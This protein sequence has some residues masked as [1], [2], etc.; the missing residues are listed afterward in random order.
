MKRLSVVRS[1]SASA[2]ETPD[3]AGR[4]VV[5]VGLDWTRDKDPRVPLGQA[6]LAAS[7]KA[8][9]AEVHSMCYSINESGLD[10]EGAVADVLAAAWTGRGWADLGIGVYVWNDGAVRALCRRLRERGFIGRIVLGGPQITYHGPGVDQRY[11]DADALVRG[12]GEA[13]LPQI[14]ASRGPVPIPG[15]CWRGEADRCEQASAALE[16][17]PSPYLTGVLDPVAHRRFLRWETKRGCL[18]RC[19]FCQHRDPGARPVVSGFAEDR[20]K[21]EIALF[22][23]AGVEEIA[24]LDPIFN[25]P[26]SPYL[27][28]LDGFIAAEFRG[29]L[30]LQCRFELVDR[31]FLERVS[32]I[33]AQLEFGLQTIHP[34]EWKGIHRGNQMDKVESAIVELQRRGI[35]FEVSLIYGLPDQTLASFRATVQWC[36]ERGVPV[37]KAFPL[38]LLRGTE[39]EQKR[40]QW[41]LVESEDTIPMVI[42]SDSFTREEHHEMQTIS[43]ALIATEGRHPRSIDELVGRMVGPVHRARWTP[44]G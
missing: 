42:A 38:M 27:E 25:D 17:L 5:L 35:F 19:S 22:A 31:A 9:G 43:E 10:I 18:Y 32:Q 21:A 44:V 15:V 14:V 37:I 39:I 11:P 34:R 20:V 40:E 2:G 12:A 30:S 8:A 41:R 16:R 23:A 4:R 7:L 6:S 3:I 36:L 28:L 29:R 33:D 24:V 26:R 1:M 13:A